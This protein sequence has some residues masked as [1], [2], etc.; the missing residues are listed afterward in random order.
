MQCHQCGTLYTAETRTTEEGLKGKFPDH[1]KPM[2]ISAKSNK[3]KHYDKVGNEINPED[4]DIIDLIKR[5][6]TVVNYHGEKA[7]VKSSF[8][9][10]IRARI[11]LY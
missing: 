8:L 5:G 6:L 3:K 11:R 7:Q 1:S 4:K 10:K 2:I 9:S